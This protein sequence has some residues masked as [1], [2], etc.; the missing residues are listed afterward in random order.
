MDHSFGSD[1]EVNHLRILQSSNGLLLCTGS[2]W[3]VFI[4][5]GVLGMAF[6]PRKSLYYKVVQAGRTSVQSIGMMPSIG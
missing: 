5:T 2:A 6:D 3:P 1:E 4:T